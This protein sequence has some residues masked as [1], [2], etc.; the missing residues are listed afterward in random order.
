MTEKQGFSWGRIAP[1]A[2]LLAALGL[3]FALGLHRAITL[4]GLRERHAAL[5]AWAA[6]APWT[7]WPIGVVAAA[8]VMAVGF[9]S[10]G[11]VMAACGLVFGLWAGFGIGLLGAT[12]GGTALFLAA[13]RARGAFM[14]SRFGETRM[15]RLI[16]ALERRAHG[17][18]A[19]YL[20]SLRLMLFLPSNTVT[21]AA[22]AAHLRLPA[23]LIG[24]LIGSGPAA[25]V[26]TTI[27]AGAGAALDAGGDVDLLAATLSP[28]VIGPLLG[29]T[30]LA[31]FAVWLR[32]RLAKAKG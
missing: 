2:L 24:T 31:V 12:I 20:V 1:L 9:P 7:A 5:Q 26:F 21:I 25:F 10:I 18:E 15:G 22:A 17:N 29:L 30:A 13:R 28:W 23:F 19:L 3:F 27:G 11:V 8:S 32:A 16:R 6:G 4:E 14:D